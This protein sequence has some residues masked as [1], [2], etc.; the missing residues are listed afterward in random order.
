MFH[1][2]FITIPIYA[3]TFRKRIK[4]STQDCNSN[5]HCTKNI[6]NYITMQHANILAYDNFLL[7]DH[8][9]LDDS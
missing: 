2:K 1:G 5:T 9:L 3:K 4:K 6:Y 8:R 7:N